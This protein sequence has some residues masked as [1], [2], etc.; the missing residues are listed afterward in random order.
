[1]CD[2]SGTDF[3]CRK[4]IT[5]TDIYRCYCRFSA[6][7]NGINE[8]V[9]KMLVVIITFLELIYLYTFSLHHG[10]VSIVSIKALQ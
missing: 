10:S 5:F 6:V 9:Q 2:R 4:L 1:M 8:Q 3:Q 7:C